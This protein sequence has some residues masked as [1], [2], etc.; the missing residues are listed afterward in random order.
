MP[1]RA[2][3]RSCALDAVNGAVVLWDGN[4]YC[5]RCADA[6][7]PALSTY[8]RTHPA[9]REVWPQSTFGVF[10]YHWLILTPGVLGV[11]AAVGVPIGW[12]FGVNPPQALG[13][14]LF[15]VFLPVL[16]PL[17]VLFS[18]GSA[19]GFSLHRPAVEVTRGTVVVRYGRA[20]EFSYPLSACEWFVGRLSQVE[21][22][23]K[24]LH[25]PTPVVILSLPHRER[26]IP[27]HAA[28]GF[29][30]ETHKRWTSFLALAGVPRQTSRGES[31]RLRHLGDLVV[32]ISSLP[33]CMGGAML[34]GWI[35]SRWLLLVAG[36]AELASVVGGLTFFVGGPTA[37]FCLFEWWPWARTRRVP[38]R[39]P[40]AEQARRK[41]HV[42]LAL[43]AMGAGVGLVFLLPSKGSSNVRARVM[44]LI[45]C[46]VWSWLFGR[47]VAGWVD[48]E[49]EPK[50]TGKG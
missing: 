39:T 5:S 40:P 23:T 25:P 48:Y 47:I 14:V 45:T 49:H 41:M 22:F 29:T 19:L 9:L 8:A 33:V 11:F 27:R 50:P 37:L 30:A 35:V 7:D 20:W 18:V 46:L 32:G 2:V 44:G 10:V 3:C 38:S 28:V 6:I 31:R 21:P 4:T 1:P 36:D 17:S 26:H 34:V 15:F 43:L 42:R 12:A 13:E 16:F 24:M